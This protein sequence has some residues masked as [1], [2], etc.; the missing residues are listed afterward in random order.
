M[1]E[2]KQEPKQVTVSFNIK[3]NGLNANSKRCYGVAVEAD[4]DEVNLVG[5]CSVEELKAFKD[6]GKV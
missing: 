6:A 2:P 3:E 1:N 5:K 4:K